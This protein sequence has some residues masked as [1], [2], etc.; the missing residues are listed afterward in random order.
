MKHDFL[1]SYLYRSFAYKSNRCNENCNEI[2]ISEHLLLN[3]CHYFN[4]QK[5]LKINTKTSIT[6]RTLLNANENIKNVLKFIK[7]T[8]ICTK[9][10]ILDKMKN[11]EMNKNE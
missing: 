5:D 6:L 4:E 7:N 3:C 2:Q 9:K 8:R 11:E 1:K 10:W